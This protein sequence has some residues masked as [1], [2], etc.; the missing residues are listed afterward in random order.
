[1]RSPMNGNKP[2][3]ASRPMVKRVPGMGIELS[4]SQARKFNRSRASRSPGVSGPRTSPSSGFSVAMR[5]GITVSFALPLKTT[6]RRSAMAIKVG[7]RL[8][9]GKLMESTEF[10]SGTQCAMPP[11]EVHVGDAVK[12]KKIAIFAVPGAYTPTCSAKHVPGYT[13]NVEQLKKKG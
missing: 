2:I 6:Y 11:E 4:S 7:D 8:P 10:D 13:Q 3:S 12:G 5:T 9:D 1:M